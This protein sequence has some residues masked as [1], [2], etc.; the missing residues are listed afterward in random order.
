MNTSQVMDQWQAH[1][2]RPTGGR[3]GIIV[4]ILD[5]GSLCSFWMVYV[6]PV[7]KRLAA[8][9][10]TDH[11]RTCIGHSLRTPTGGRRPSS[12]AVWLRQL[13][14]S[15]APSS[16]ATEVR[17]PFSPA[18]ND[19]GEAREANARLRRSVHGGP[20]HPRFRELIHRRHGWPAY[21][22][23]RTPP[24]PGKGLGHCEL[25][26]RRRVHLVRLAGAGHHPYSGRLVLTLAH[27][28]AGLP[29]AAC[30]CLHPLDTRVPR[31]IGI[32]FYCWSRWPW[33]RSTAG[34][35]CSQTTPTRYMRVPASTSRL[36]KYS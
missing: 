2:D 7:K 15:S 27:P 21:H 14:P 31:A 20:V 19:E 18:R 1:F 3:L 36:T 9:R 5:N 12:S 26:V 29:R 30:A 17:K 23:G 11:D 25:H 34:V 6:G 32:A 10:L 8:V 24:A 22:R 16:T 4:A 35:I 28:V 13:V 33:S